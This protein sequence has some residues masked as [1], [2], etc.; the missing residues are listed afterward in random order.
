MRPIFLCF[1]DEATARTVLNK[2]GWTPDVKSN[3]AQG[4]DW[5]IQLLGLKATPGY[6]VNALAADVPA[7]LSAYVI[8]PATPDCI[9]A[10]MPAV[11]P[12][13]GWA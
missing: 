4:P 11:R 12:V 9:F 10:G 2:C 8:N 3:Y 7:S 13:G 1:P 5:A 6:Y